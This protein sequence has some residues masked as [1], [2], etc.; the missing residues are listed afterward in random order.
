MLFRIPDTSRIALHSRRHCGLQLQYAYE[1]ETPQ[2]PPVRVRVW[3][4]EATLSRP[5]VVQV[6]QELNHLSFQLPLTLRDQYASASLCPP[7]TFLRV[8]SRRSRFVPFRPFPFPRGP[9]IHASLSRAPTHL[10]SISVQ[11]PQNTPLAV[12]HLFINII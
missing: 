1:Y 11:S 9:V 5:L 3:S 2:P 8:A 7:L 10:V 4:A 6:T 12:V